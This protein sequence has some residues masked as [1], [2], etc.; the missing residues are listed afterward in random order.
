MIPTLNM[1]KPAVADPQPVTMMDLCIALARME[2]RAKEAEHVRDML[3]RR[4]AEQA[5]HIAGLISLQ[6]EESAEAERHPLADAIAV[7]QTAGV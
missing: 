1:Q 3:A 7:M 4:C 6:A 5:H 2:R